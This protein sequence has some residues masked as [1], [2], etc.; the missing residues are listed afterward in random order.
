M[1][2]LEDSH[3]ELHVADPY[4]LEPGS[5]QVPLSDS[6]S[7]ST[8]DEITNGQRKKSQKT[9]KRKRRATEPA[10][11]GETLQSLLSTQVASAG[12]LSLTPSATKK[13]ADEKIE[14]KA[15]TALQLEKKDKEDKG[16]IT[17]VIGGWG[18][19]RER[20]L[21]KVAQRGGQ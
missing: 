16:R 14:L 10:R 15:R 13:K 7:P 12:P 1:P 20:A 11:F 6:E 17:D 4:L 5:D 3:S 9:L 8:A 19:E 2:S 18:G 21:R